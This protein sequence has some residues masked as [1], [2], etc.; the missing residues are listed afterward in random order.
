MTNAEKKDPRSPMPAAVCRHFS[1][2][3]RCHAY[4]LNSDGS[5][6]CAFSGGQPSSHYED[7]DLLHA[8]FGGEPV[9]GWPVLKQAR[10]GE[11]YIA[12]DLLDGDEFSGRLAVGPVMGAVKSLTE[13]R[14]TGTYS[15]NAVSAAVLLYYMVYSQWADEKKL[16]MS[17]AEDDPDDNKKGKGRPRSSAEQEKIKHHS[18]AYEN[19]IFSLITEGNEKQLMTLIKLP[20]DGEYGMLDREHPLRNIKDDCICIITLATRAAI[21]GGLDSETAFLMSDGAIQNLE[22]FRDIDS[23]Y[24]LMVETLC[25]FA[26]KVAEIKQRGCSYRVNCCRSY[27]QNHIYEKLTVRSIAEHLRV[28]PEYLSEQFKNQTGTK[29]ID[30]ITN[31]RAAEAKRLLLYSNKSILEIASLLNYHDQSHFTK[32]FKSVFG[33]TPGEYRKQPG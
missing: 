9:R 2:L 22:L 3:L 11:T 4:C 14:S 27:V 32:S 31:V 29:L 30:Y 16:S 19:H 28:S 20:P 23:I 33:R 26:H 8:L 24:G 7:S 21:S 1:S 12:V 13:G 15:D 25:R 10:P 17:K 6:R 18:I 5:I